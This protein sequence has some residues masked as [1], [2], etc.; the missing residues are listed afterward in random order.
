MFQ[1]CALSLAAQPPTPTGG[2]LPLRRR[3]EAPGRGAWS[4]FCRE[5]TDPIYPGLIGTLWSWIWLIDVIRRQ[6]SG[7]IG[8]VNDLLHFKRQAHTWSG[9]HP[10]SS[11][12]FGTKSKYINFLSRCRMWKCMRNVDHWGTSVS[13]TGW[14]QTAFGWI[15]MYK[16]ENRKKNNTK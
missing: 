10:L 14:N 16:L 11:G 5:C 9:P 15:G 4:G 1:V 12:P 2:P 3:L 6:I 8:S 13:T 7:N